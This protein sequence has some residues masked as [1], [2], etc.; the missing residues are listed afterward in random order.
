M[1][2]TVRHL[3]SFLLAGL[4]GAP[5]VASAQT[6]GFALDQFEPSERGSEWFANE[7]LDLRGQLRP[8]AGIVADYANRPLAIYNDDGSVRSALVQDQFF[9]HVGASLVLADRVRVAVSLPVAVHEDGQD[10]TFDGA[11]YSA[12]GN[13]SVGD[14]RLGGDVRLLGRYADTFTVAAGLQLFV[15]TG[16]RADYTSDGSV[17][18]EPRIM[19]AG[20]DGEFSYALRVG[21][22]Y[23]GV[24]SSYGGTTVGSEVTYG[25]SL[26]IRVLDRKLLVGPELFGAA[27]AS[28]SSQILQKR[29]TP[30]EGI[31]GAHYQM[32]SSWRIGIG[33]GGGL[34]RGYGSPTG[35]LVG[36]IEWAPR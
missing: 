9:V 29:T 32:S 6:A 28:D 35:R 31:V 13:F 3:V 33:G 18:L 12:P 1:S 30:L 4:F 27:D 36:G 21:F 14:L 16:S 7:S 34:T 11:S 8:A 10:G 20:D 24:T 17:R 22:E 2:S 5:A 25:A 15:P 26:G 23:A 19:A